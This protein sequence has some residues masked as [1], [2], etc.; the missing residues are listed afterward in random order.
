MTTKR[1]L[2]TFS[3]VTQYENVGDAWINRE[4]IRLIAAR[5]ELQLEL[6][7]VPQHF[8]SSLGLENTE[9]TRI[10]GIGRLLLRQLVARFTG[11][12]SYN[13]M[14]PGA[15]FGELHGMRLLRSWVLAGLVF[16]LRLIGVRV[17][18]A[19]ASYENL[20]PRHRRMLA[21]RSRW[22]FAHMV[23]DSSSAEYARSNG[24]RVTGVIPDLSLA[25]Q[26]LSEAPPESLPRVIAF[27]FRTDQSP[28]H[29]Q[30]V[31]DGLLKLARA[32]GKSVVWR[33]IVQ[34][35]RDLPGMKELTQLLREENIEVSDPIV[36]A[37]DL[38]A[39]EISY[40][41]C[42]YVLGNRLHALLLGASQCAIPWA[43]IDPWHN[44]KIQR[45]FSELG[46]ADQV[47]SIA[48]NDSVE[49]LAARLVAGMGARLDFAP[50]R[51]AL[52]RIFD[53]IIG[54]PL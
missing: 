48:K 30:Q 16:F 49:T 54:S 36:V 12:C 6:S 38:N 28:E 21:F 14:S 47:F 10:D 32:L 25:T 4:L 26:G 5:T 3:V 43:W 41:G 7:R 9:S 31:S 20:G 27:S 11:R 42:Q 51:E 46:L 2:A 52:H 50:Y 15:N 39:A 22:L 17:V 33:P 34:V 45:I 1:P 24:I 13:F 29:L 53:D 37:D 40:S 18:L 8:I 35:E 23:R 44:I 19:G